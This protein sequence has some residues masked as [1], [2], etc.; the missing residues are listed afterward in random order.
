MDM[1]LLLLSWSSI[2]SVD[3]ILKFKSS[4]KKR[5]KRNWKESW[6]FSTH[7]TTIIVWE[8]ENVKD[9]IFVI[10]QEVQST[11]KLNETSLSLRLR[12]PRLHL[13]LTRLRLLIENNRFS[14]SLFH[15]QNSQLTDCVVPPKKTER[16]KS[17]INIKSSSSSLCLSNSN[18]EV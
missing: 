4:W 1:C 18:V 15:Q 9:A 17:T 12:P 6:R 7:S 16:K 5:W 8:H 14:H 2:V 13:R 11:A 10:F 3:G